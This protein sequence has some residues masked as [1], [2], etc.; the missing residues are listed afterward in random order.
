MGAKVSGKQPIITLKACTGKKGELGSGELPKT[1][2]YNGTYYESYVKTQ[3]VNGFVE[4]YYSG[5][6]CSNFLIVPGTSLM[7]N[8]TLG[9]AYFIFLLYLFLGISINADIFMESI[10]VITSS[11]KDVVVRDKDDKLVTY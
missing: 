8:A 1:N 11:T 2:C 7:S 5:E 9:I 10:E 4:E 3:N 6:F